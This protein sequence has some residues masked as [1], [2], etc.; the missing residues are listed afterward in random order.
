M[1]DILL[2][3]FNA[4]YIHTAFGL[5]CLVANLGEFASRAQI[6][7]F[8]LD[9]RPLDAAEDIL[10]REPKL[11]GIGVYIWNAEPCA[12]LV[13]LLKVLRP[14]LPLVLGGPEVSHETE[15]QAMVQTADY[16]VLGEGELAFRDLCRALLAGERPQGKIIPGGLPPLAELTSPY[17]LYLETD[18]A[19]RLVYVEASRGCPFRCAFC[20]SALDQRVRAF[21]LERFLADIEALFQRGVRH[22]KFVDR[23]FNL[24]IPTASAILD[25][26]LDRLQPGLF[27][28]FEMIPDRLP[29]A[30]KDRLRRFPAGTLQLEIGIQ[31]FHPEVQ[32]RIDRR[33]DN[34]LAEANLRWLRRETQAHL[35]TDLILGLPGEELR[36]FGAGFDRLLALEPQEIQVGLLKRLRG[37]PINR[38]T[39]TFGLV[40]HP[41]APYELL[42]NRDIDF[43]SLQRMKRFARYW[44]LLGNSGR[45]PHSRGL[46]VEDGSPFERFLQ[47]SDWIY[48]TTRQTQAIALQRWY[49]LLSRGLTEA[50]G[51]EPSQV[52][53]AVQADW[54]LAAAAERR[55]KLEAKTQAPKRQG[56]HELGGGVPSG[57]GFKA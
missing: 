55:S 45:F 54:E 39:Q 50:L 17:G 43:L 8:D 3:T 22:F 32:H 30:L 10:A 9:K 33:Q 21:P 28:H 13:G 26:F 49:D 2:V 25:F 52:L 41:K 53:A 24:S 56:R 15:A 1:P 38:H 47:L 4:R 7:E 12:E 37:A 11:V 51:L 19:H 57:F 42:Y 23:T 48:A 35:H 40:Y 36:S 34:E 31:S 46:I 16:V 5:R 29:E 18:I 27:L 44:D 6:L 20:L 14:D